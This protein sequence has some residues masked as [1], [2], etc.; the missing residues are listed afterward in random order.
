[1]LKTGYTPLILFPDCVL[2]NCPDRSD[3]PH[4]HIYPQQQNIL[5]ST[6]KYLYMQG[7]VGGGKT[8]AFAAK[9]VH[10]SITIAKN[11]G[12]V[13]RFNLDQLY[14]TTWREFNECVNRA[15]EKEF[16]PK[17]K[18]SNK[19]KG[20]YTKIEFW[21]GSEAY[22]IHG[23]S[24]SSG[25]GA[26]HGWFLVDDAL[27]SQ[28]EFFVGTNTTAGIMSRLRL[29]N[30]WQDEKTFNEQSRPWGSLHGMIVTNPPPYGHYLHNLFGDK[31]G[32]HKIG[33]DV[34]E[35]ILG[36]STDNA[37]TGAAYAKG[38][39]A[40][41]KQMGRS[42]GSV[43]RIV[44][45][46]SV[47]AY[48]GIPVYPQFDHKVHVA[49]LKCDPNIPVICAVDFGAIHPAI[50]YSHLFKCKYNM[51]HY[52]TLSEIADAKH[53]TIYELWDNYA[54][55]HERA[56]YSKV[57]HM[58]YAG[59]RSG[60]RQSSSNRD[61]RSDMK[62]L[63]HEYRLPFRHKYMSL[64]PSLQ[65][66][67]SLLKPKKPCLC[68]MP[69]ILISNTCEALI[70]A[71]EGGYRYP[72]AKGRPQGEKPHEDRLFADVACAWRY[73]AENYVKWGIDWREQQEIE[74]ERK[75]VLHE[76]R[77]ARQEETPSG[78]TEEISD[79]YLEA[80][81]DIRGTMLTS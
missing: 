47:P 62:I 20:N 11:R 79:E 7:G 12:I 36:Q 34:V 32:I 22:A 45:G 46:E 3:T 75:Q 37:S 80:L 74:A 4:Q 23:K 26:N 21:N 13:S 48:A 39:I 69:Y 61:A 42:A 64:E 59:D 33:E 73:G 78:W 44:Y 72:K 19:V 66:M 58:L 17:P 63:I 41:Q 54:I 67:R 77:I 28:E 76:A 27:E 50:V 18:Y 55:P 60:F 30:V 15:V 51:N 6:A 1:M 52:F 70:G 56:L 31:P 14:D 81:L 53:V 25:L 68:G 9:A 65:Y 16:I 8:T 38:L 5:N 49:P 29:P 24:V 10:L 57:K 71:L 40:V 35:W 2:L 43:R